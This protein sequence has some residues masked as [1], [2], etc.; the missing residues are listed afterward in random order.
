M[1]GDLEPALEAERERNL[2]VVRLTAEGRTKSYIQS[3]TGVPPA[4]QRKINEEFKQY[5]RNDLYTQQRSREIIGYFDEHY[6]SLIQQMYEVVSEADMNGDYKNKGNALKL[7]AEMEAKR[8]DALQKAG[9][10]SA[11]SIGDEVAQMQIKHEKIISLLK[12]VATQYPA[13]A[14]LI[15]QGIADIQNEVIAT[16]VVNE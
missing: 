15:A 1:S 8:V 11:Q 2:M 10:L 14:E 7:I 12:D 5:A 6:S 4:A 13:A 16:H 9:V 3:Q